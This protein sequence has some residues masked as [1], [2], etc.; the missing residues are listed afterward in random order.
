MGGAWS[1]PPPDFKLMLLCVQAVTA[2]GCP[3][4]EKN[5]RKKKQLSGYNVYVCYAYKNQ[6][7][8]VSK[9]MNSALVRCNSILE[10]KFPHFSKVVYTPIM[11]AI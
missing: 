1:P 10:A 6:G 5:E 3:K 11:L 8:E 4:L 9:Y 7:L 2:K